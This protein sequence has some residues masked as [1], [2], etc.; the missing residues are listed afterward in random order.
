[1]K[2]QNVGMTNYQKQQNFAALPKGRAP[3][4]AELVT[5]VKSVLESGSKEAASQ[6]MTDYKAVVTGISPETD[7]LN[8]AYFLGGRPALPK[9]YD[10]F[11]IPL[12]IKSLAP[13]TL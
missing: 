10:L 12:K 5:E 13:R 6:L 7:I 2:V 11:G 1:M 8:I 4:L 3:E 9:A